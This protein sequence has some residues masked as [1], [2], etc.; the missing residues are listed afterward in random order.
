MSSSSNDATTT[1]SGSRSYKRHHE[2]DNNGNCV[3]VMSSVDPS[4][5]RGPTAEHSPYCMYNYICTC[6]DQP[7]NLLDVI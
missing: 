5:I 3:V 4:M 2:Q 1:M 7:L 6:I